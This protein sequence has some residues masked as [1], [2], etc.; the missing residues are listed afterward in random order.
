[1]TLCWLSRNGGK[2]FRFNKQEN[3]SLLCS[4]KKTHKCS[5]GPDTKDRWHALTRAQMVNSIPTTTKHRKLYESSMKVFHDH[6]PFGK[7]S[8][9]LGDHPDIWETYHIYIIYIIYIY[10][11]YYIFYIL[12]IYILYILYILY[13]IY[14][15][16]YIYIYYIYI[17]YTIYILYI[18]YIYIYN[19]LIAQDWHPTKTSTE[20]TL[21]FAGPSR[22]PWAFS[23]CCARSWVRDLSNAVHW[24]S[25]Y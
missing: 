25:R 18:Y 15:Y 20:G 22:S 19:P 17:I 13:I 6:E 10:I 9:H 11:I 24:K 8:S 12:Y 2:T 16:I 1:M 7:I 4:Q 3:Y 5:I 23:S 21:K 14:I